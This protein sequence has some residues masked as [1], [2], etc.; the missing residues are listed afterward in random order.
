MEERAQLNDNGTQAG[1]FWLR[2]FRGNSSV[3]RT[4]MCFLKVS[5]T[6]SWSNGS[7]NGPAAP[8][9]TMWAQYGSF[10][11]LEDFDDNSEPVG[12]P[13]DKKL[14]FCGERSSVTF[15]KQKRK[16]ISTALL[17]LGNNTNVATE[18]EVTRKQRAKCSPPTEFKAQFYSH[19]M[20][21]EH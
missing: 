3:K 15:Y 21:K 10:G 18:N 6:S 17:V 5:T 4:Q 2:G 12:N 7:C 11:K 13:D 14:A 8:F 16:R 9:N 19:W 20:N 1:T